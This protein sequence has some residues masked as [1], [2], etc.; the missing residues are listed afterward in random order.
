MAE[1]LRLKAQITQMSEAFKLEKMKLM[2]LNDEISKK[3]GAK[4]AISAGQTDSKA[5]NA[6]KKENV[7]DFE[8]E[9]AALRNEYRELEEKFNKMKE[10]LKEKNEKVRKNIL[11]AN[12]FIV[13]IEGSK[14]EK[15]FG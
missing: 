14:I 12:F 7:Q 8:A 2:K 4:A 15:F 11:P 1:N 13:F 3:K 6:S 5:K 10:T 9:K